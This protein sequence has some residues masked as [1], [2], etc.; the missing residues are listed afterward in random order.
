M[1]YI[2]GLILMLVGGV[3]FYKN[4][5]EKAETDSKL[6][7]IRGKDSQLSVNQKDVQDTIKSL[8][9]GIAKLQAEREAKRQRDK[10]MTLKERAEAMRKNLK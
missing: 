9:D 3:F 8:D 2:I 4:K 6:A 5:S 7:E 1:E 10:N